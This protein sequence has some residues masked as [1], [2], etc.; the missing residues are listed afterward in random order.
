MTLFENLPQAVP[1]CERQGAGRRFL[2]ATIGL[3][4][5]AQVLWDRA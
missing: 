4:L 3:R 1:G 5:A 2:R